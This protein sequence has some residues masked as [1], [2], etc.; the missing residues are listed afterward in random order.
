MLWFIRLLENTS[1]YQLWESTDCSGAVEA[2]SLESDTLKVVGGEE[3]RKRKEIGNRQKGGVQRMGGQLCSCFCFPYWGPLLSFP[4]LSGFMHAGPCP[5]ISPSLVLVLTLFVYLHSSAKMFWVSVCAVLMRAWG[6]QT[7]MRNKKDVMVDT[8]VDHS[9]RSS[10]IGPK[11]Q[12]KRNKRQH[13]MNAK[14]MK[15][16]LSNVFHHRVWHIIIA[17]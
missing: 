3:R 8:S 17:S 12:M 11:C 9:H 10:R 7:R 13:E 1:I 15:S 4:Q 5:L 6:V 14:W 2:A 16:Y